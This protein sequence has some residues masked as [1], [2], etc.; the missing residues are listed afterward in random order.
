MSPREARRSK[1]ANQYGPQAKEGGKVNYHKFRTQG[2]KDK[3]LTAAQRCNLF[4]FV[5][6]VFSS[7]RSEWVV[8]KNFLFFLPLKGVLKRV[9]GFQE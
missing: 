6:F 7:E 5:F 3:K 4:F 8:K 9:T 2:K 1:R